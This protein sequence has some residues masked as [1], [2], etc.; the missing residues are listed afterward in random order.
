MEIEIRTNHNLSQESKN[1]VEQVEFEMLK[2]RSIF[3][4]EQ[5][6]ILI[7]TISAA[8][9]AGATKIAIEVIRAKA[10]LEI[11]IGEKKFKGVKE[12]DVIK[13]LDAIDSQDD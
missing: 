4:G 11:T 5:L 10:N 8:T 9:I 13:F 12:D 2:S 6:V 7:G 3:G 1:T